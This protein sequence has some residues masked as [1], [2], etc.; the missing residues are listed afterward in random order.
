MK[1]KNILLPTDF[2]ENAWNAT[3]YA[4]EM[5][6]DE[7]CIL[8]LLNTYTPA[9]IHSRFMAV[10]TEG[11]LLEDT[12]HAASE[13]G[14]QKLLDRLHLK[15][16]NPKH[17][18]R[19]ISSFNLLTEQVKETVEE[20]AIDMVITGT[21]GASGFKEIFLGSNA[22]RIIRSV[23]TC[24]ILVVPEST[25]YKPPKQ[26]ALATNFQRSFD[27]SVLEPLKNLAKQFN[28]V[29]RI[30]HI[31]EKKQLDKYQQSNL[32]ILKEYLSGV[33]S[34]LHWMPYFS[35]KADVIKTFIE[36]LDIDI[37]AMI[38]YSHSFLEELTREPVISK[39]AFH[40]NIPLLTIPE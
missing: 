28:A 24:P 27:A 5:F 10:N 16:N 15:T 13:L 20:L 35:S 33:V 12:C 37:L 7:E 4:L 6:K 40:T 23:K 18:F 9:I 2:S 3:N 11:R 32:D 19:T 38:H 1:V 25:N 22:V 36:E 21:Q 26:I 39:M 14:L 30:V 17:Q 34:S 31:S 29:V 8:H